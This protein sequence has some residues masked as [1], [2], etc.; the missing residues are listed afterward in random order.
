MGVPSAS[1]ASWQLDPGT[2]PGVR[3]FIV[4][5]DSIY[6]SGLQAT[7]A[8]DPGIESVEH[9]TSVAVASEQESLDEADVLLLDSGVAGAAALVQE[10][11]VESNIR[12]L[13]C[14]H[15]PTG[16]DVLE[17][18]GI[19]VGGALTRELMT[20]QS[21]V[22]AVTAVASGI[23]ALDAGTLRALT[24][25][26]NGSAEAPRVA[27]Q[28]RR[29]STR[30]QRVLSLV[31]AGLSNR[32]IAQRLSYSERTIKMVLHDI[33]TKLGVKSRSQAVA[34]AVRERII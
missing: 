28:G 6:A 10:L 24:T 23:F 15:A 22:A 8:A 29:F 11:R 13:I 32:E 2:K 7:L 14:L 18:C 26:A 34:L 4:F 12:I 21:V 3:V 20:P 1:A 31:A 5:Q 16:R 27:L 17:A 19:G 30:E 33:V 25:A 9:T